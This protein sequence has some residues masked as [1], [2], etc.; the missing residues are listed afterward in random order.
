[1]I[2][3]VQDFAQCL[4]HIIRG[5]V[6]GDIVSDDVLHDAFFI[7]DHKVY[8]ERPGTGIYGYGL[9]DIDQRHNRTIAKRGYLHIDRCIGRGLQT[10]V[11]P[12]LGPCQLRNILS[13]KV[14]A[15]GYPVGYIA[16]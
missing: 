1:M 3:R 10:G 11:I 5:G 8:P 15:E 4:E 7:L 13:G 16:G 2:V 6:E 12:V 9:Q 14:T